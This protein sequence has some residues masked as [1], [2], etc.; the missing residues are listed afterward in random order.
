[1]YCPAQRSAEQIA[2]LDDLAVEIDLLR[3]KTLEREGKDL[4]E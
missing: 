4:R 3:L 2:Q 1:L